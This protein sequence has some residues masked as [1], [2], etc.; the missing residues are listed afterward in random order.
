MGLVEALESARS[1]GA[2]ENKSEF[3][4]PRFVSDAG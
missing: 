2:R 3:S 1:V 4:L